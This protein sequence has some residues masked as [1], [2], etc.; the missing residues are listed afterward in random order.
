[1]GQLDNLGNASYEKR[2][3]RI[4]IIRRA[5]DNQ[6]LVTVGSVVKKY[7]YKENTVIGWAKSG[8][9]PLLDNT[10]QPVVPVTDSNRPKWLK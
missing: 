9:I 10:G 3:Q 7:G 8:D 4:M 6:E 2:Q 5:F 1:M